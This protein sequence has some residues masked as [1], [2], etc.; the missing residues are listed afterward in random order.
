[1]EK[2]FQCLFSMNDSKHVWSFCFDYHIYIT[3]ILCFISNG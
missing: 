2:I 1:M 3:I